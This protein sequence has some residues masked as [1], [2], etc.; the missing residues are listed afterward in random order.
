M[1]V[2]SKQS[3]SFS[4]WQA[5]ER[6]KTFFYLAKIRDDEVVVLVGHLD[7]GLLALAQAGG[8][9]ARTVVRRVVRGLG[10]KLLG[11]LRGHPAGIGRLVLEE[12]DVSEPVQL[13]EPER[14]LLLH[15]QINGQEE[16]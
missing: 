12:V 7:P 8:G 11:D 1:L 15:L 14:R 10:A 2:H 13:L 4:C 3:S 5:Q 6:N 9:F 16:A